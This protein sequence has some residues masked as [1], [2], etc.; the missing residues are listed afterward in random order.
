MM[1]EPLPFFS[2]TGPLAGWELEAWYN[3]LQDIMCSEVETAGCFQVGGCEEQGGLI[4]VETLDNTSFQWTF[5]TID[6]PLSVEFSQEDV[7]ALEAVVDKL[8]SDEILEFINPGTLV[9]TAPPESR[10]DHFQGGASEPEPCYSSSPSQTLTEDEESSTSSCGTK[11]KRNSKARGGKIRVKERDQDNDRK[12]DYFIAENE[13]LKVEIERLTV[14]V[15]KTRKDL[16][17]R[18]VTTRRPQL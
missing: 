12:V 11:R 17:E 2:P 3:D 5:E 10:A 9:S 7:V 18:M 14:E 15:E 16:I 4:Q 6:S 1:A 13:R 8:P